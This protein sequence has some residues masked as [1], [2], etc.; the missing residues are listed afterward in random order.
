CQQGD[1]YPRTF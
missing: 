1:S